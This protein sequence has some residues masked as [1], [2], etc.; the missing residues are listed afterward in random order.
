[1]PLSQGDGVG[2]DNPLA[3]WNDGTTKKS[4]LDFVARVT[5]AGGKDYVA[6][7]QRIATFDNDGTLWSERPYPFQVAFAF[8]RLKAMAPKPREWGEKNPS[9]P[10]WQATS[11][12]CFRADTMRLSR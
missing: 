7:E 11:M 1:M 5:E 6:P 4:I 8:D 12:E 10:R 2:T 3:S 9:N